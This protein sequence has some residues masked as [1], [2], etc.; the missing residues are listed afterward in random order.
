MITHQITVLEIKDIRQELLLTEAILSLAKHRHEMGS[1]LN[2]DPEQLIAIM[3]NNGLYTSAARLALQLGKSVASILDNLA[4]ACIRASEEN[5][6]EA[7]SWLQENDL[8]GVCKILQCNVF[9]LTFVL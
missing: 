8:A 1:I 3:T 9:L 6:S 2:A 4:V 7:W 5:N